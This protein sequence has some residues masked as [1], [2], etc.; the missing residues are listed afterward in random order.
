[1]A[2]A[3][4][5]GL[6]IVLVPGGAGSGF[7]TSQFDS[8]Q[9]TFLAKGEE[10]YYAAYAWTLSAQIPYP[11]VGPIGVAAGI[12]PGFEPPP[13]KVVKEVLANIY[14]W[15][16]TN[17]ATNDPNFVYLYG[18][19]Y[20]SHI[21]GQIAHPPSLEIELLKSLLFGDS[22]DL[23]ISFGKYVT[24]VGWANAYPHHFD[25]VDLNLYCLSGDWAL[26]SASHHQWPLELKPPLPWWQPGNYNTR[27][28]LPPAC[29]TPGGKDKVVELRSSP[30]FAFAPAHFTH[31]SFDG[32]QTLCQ[33]PSARA[34]M[35]QLI[36][37]S[38]KV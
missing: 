29:Y 33:L 3:D 27:G 1:M 37:D 35:H 24:T 15:L 22:S 26:A 8:L 2:A 7:L 25:R 31:Q 23:Q 36:M 28:L 38:L 17:P 30:P 18:H 6:Y 20:G 34:I 16:L 4:P 13:P 11:P 5:E 12:I 19:S 9:K 21:I 32:W 10:A 14:A